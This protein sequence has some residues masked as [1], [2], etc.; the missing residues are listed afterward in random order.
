VTDSQPSYQ[1]AHKW[2]WEIKAPVLHWH[3]HSWTH[4]HPGHTHT[5]GHIPTQVTHTLM[6]TY[7][8]RSHTH[9]WIHTHPGHTHTHGHIPTQVTHTL[10]DT[11][12]P[13]SHTHSWTHTHTHTLTH[14]HTHT[15]THFL[16]RN[17]I[18]MRMVILCGYVTIYP[19][20]LSLFWS[21]ISPSI[22][23]HMFKLLSTSVAWS[24]KSH[25]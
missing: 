15:H 25:L 16:T 9:S 18:S 8:H 10:M 21:N 2:L 22:D 14:T 17:I 5:H 20:R 11:Y 6:D 24:R 12:P 1:A 3:L 7:P 19:K 23:K 13:R 4:T